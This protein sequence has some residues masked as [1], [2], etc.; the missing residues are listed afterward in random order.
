ML[1]RTLYMRDLG[2]IKTEPRRYSCL[3]RYI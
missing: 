2:R 3:Y 1:R